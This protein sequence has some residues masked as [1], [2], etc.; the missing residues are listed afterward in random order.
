MLGLSHV[1]SPCVREALSGRLRGATPRLRV[2]LSLMASMNR[3]IDDDIRE[4]VDF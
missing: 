3:D 1:P 4:A 2:E